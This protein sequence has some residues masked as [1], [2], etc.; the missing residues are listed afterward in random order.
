MRGHSRLKNGVLS[1]AYDP[2]IHDEI[3]KR[4]TLHSADFLESHHGLPGQARQ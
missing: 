3:Q 4:P 2:R 1:N